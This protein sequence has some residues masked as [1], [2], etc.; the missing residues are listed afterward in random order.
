MQKKKK[1]SQF[2]SAFLCFGIK[3]NLVTLV[4]LLETLG[5]CASC[6]SIVAMSGI[7]APGASSGQCRWHRS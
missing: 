6:L 5:F 2:F 7:T 4:I 3:C 1:V